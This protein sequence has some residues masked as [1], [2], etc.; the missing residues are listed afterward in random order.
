MS[1]VN[2]KKIKFSYI[3]IKALSSDLRHKNSFKINN[4]NSLWNREAKKNKIKSVWIVETYIHSQN[5]VDKEKC[6][7]N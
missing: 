4:K 3:E 1:V 6:K 2:H 7:R 5:N